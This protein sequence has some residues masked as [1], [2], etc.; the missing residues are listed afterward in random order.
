MSQ[1]AERVPQDKDMPFYNGNGFPRN[2][3]PFSNGILNLDTLEMMSHTRDYISTF[4]LPY[5][6]D[7][8]A[9][10]P[11]WLKFLGEVFEGD[12][13]KSNLLQEWFGYCLMPTNHF[14]KTMMLVGLQRSGKGTTMRI[15]E[16]L[17]GKDNAIGYNL[18]S[19]IDR[20]GLYPLVGKQ[21]AMIGEVNL[22]G[23]ERT[24]ILEKWK[25]VIGQDAVCIEEKHIAKPM[26]CILP[27]KFICAANEM[28]V[29]NDPSGALASRL[30]IL[31]YNRTFLG[32][33]DTDLTAKLSSEISGICNWAIAGL[34]RLA[35]GKFTVPQ[36]SV[37]RV[38]EARRENSET[39]AFLQDCIV[40]ESRLNSGQLDGVMMTD[41][42]AS[43]TSDVL[44]EL[45][46]SWA[47]ASHRTPD[48]KWFAR[49]LR[50]VIPK[51]Q[52]DREQVNGK[53][54]RIYRGIGQRYE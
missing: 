38:N 26:S 42:E 10:C 11:L 51:L 40:V 34:K 25:S 46:I 41:K 52:V 5:A 33:E 13:G 28:P 45:F 14:Q 15:L 2:V 30:L 36:S 6:Y 20:F 29:F 12:D 22:V 35:T 23:R 3:L 27:V 9:D 32:N 16:A 7:L 47:N 53:R 24:Q 44:E 21:L 1:A 37:E 31:E 19:L 43:I 8:A 48:F 18:G 54:V 50:G 39:F 4:C 17:V 49:G